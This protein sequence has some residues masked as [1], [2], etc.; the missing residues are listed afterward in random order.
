MQKEGQRAED[1]MKL[2]KQLPSAEQA[3]F[4]RLLKDGLSG[5]DDMEEYLT[6]QRFSG[7]RVCPMCGSMHV[8]RNGKRGNGT[9]KF[10]CRDCGKSFSIRKNTVFSGTHKGLSTW[11]EY[12][13][14]MAEGLTVSESAGRCGI[15][16]G[17]SFNWR[18]KI[19]DSLGESQKG[20]TLSGI[21]EADETFVPVSYKGGGSVSGKGVSRK[22]HKR[23]G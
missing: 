5:S 2:Y 19:L 21:V 6:E 13:E 18:H 23:G 16:E 17:T 9:Q 12:M 15:S 1:V 22:P 11:K 3:G 14:C 4:H 8:C 7:G 10:V 20:V